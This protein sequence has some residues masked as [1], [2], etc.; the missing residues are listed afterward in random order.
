MKRWVDNM[1]FLARQLLCLVALVTL[2]VSSLASEQQ[3][4]AQRPQ[5]AVLG[6]LTGWLL[7]SAPRMW[8][9]R[10]FRNVIFMAIMTTKV[11]SV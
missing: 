3:V 11:R 6:N 8:D 4:A 10:F 2:A 9:P 5:A 7:V 1:G